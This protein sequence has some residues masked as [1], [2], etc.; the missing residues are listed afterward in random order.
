MES[1]SKLKQEGLLDDYKSKFDTLALKV[2]GL[3]EAHKLSC[4][5]GGLKEEIQLPL[6]MF[7]PKNLVDAYALAQIQEEY[8]MNA[9]KGFRS[10]W[11]SVQMTQSHRGLTIELLVGIAKGSSFTTTKNTRP[12]PLRQNYLPPP[13]GVSNQAEN[14]SP[15]LPLV[16]VQKITQAQMEERKRKGLC[17]SCDA[18][19]TRG[20]VCQVPKLFL[21]EAVDR[22]EEEGG[23][24]ASQA[25]EDPGQF[26]LEKFPKILLNAITG[27]PS[28]KTM[29][30]V[31]IIRFRKAII[32]IDSGS[33]HNFVDTKLAAALGIQPSGK[34]GIKVKIANGQEVASQGRSREVEV[35]M[36]GH[37]FRTEFFILSL[38]GC[39]AVLGI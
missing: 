12:I 5:M 2:Q 15:S 30:I 18:K 25:E 22:E 35:K 11:C 24:A 33:T 23:K 29:R 1:L 10:S 27:S 28:P 17:Y 36:Q 3:P 39:D 19:W 26:F 8:M 34:D 6:R 32:L 4:F 14:V 7:N 21:I 38:A 13:G 37:L 9:A 16:L 31:G 20:H